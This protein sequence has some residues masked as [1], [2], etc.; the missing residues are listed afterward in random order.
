VE[1]RNSL[2]A[3]VAVVDSERPNAR[4][5]AE[6]L[7]QAFSDT[8][9]ALRGKDLLLLP[10]P[11][12]VFDRVEVERVR[13]ERGQGWAAVRLRRPL[14]VTAGQV[15]HGT[16]P[17]RQ[18]WLLRHRDQSG[19]E[20]VLPQ[21]DIYFPRDAAVRALAHQLTALTDQPEASSGLRETA[22]LVRL[23]NALLQ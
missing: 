16:P 1:G 7:S 4:E 15:R 11:L 20:V 22:Q 18:R 8:A 13:I 14:P 10:Q 21:G 3:R 23:L 5:I 19:W 2:V 6:A 9:E 17:E 12:I